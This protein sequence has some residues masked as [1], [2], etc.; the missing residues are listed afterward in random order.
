MKEEAMT[1]EEVERHH[2][3][4]EQERLLLQVGT[5]EKCMSVFVK[6]RTIDIP[7]TVKLFRTI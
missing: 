6:P 2:I 4:L 3:R 1:P 7:Y 5:V